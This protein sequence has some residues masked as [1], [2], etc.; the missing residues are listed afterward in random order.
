[1]ATYHPVDQVTEQ[2]ARS[3]RQRP[4]REPQAALAPRARRPPSSRRSPGPRKAPVSMAR[5]GSGAWAIGWATHCSLSLAIHVDDQPRHV[6]D[7]IDA[8][9]LEQRVGRL[10]ISVR[11]GG[12]PHDASGAGLMVER[13]N[14]ERED[15]NGAALE[16]LGGSAH[17]GDQRLRGDVRELRCALWPYRVG[18]EVDVKRQPVR[19]QQARKGV[20]VDA[21]ALAHQTE[22][23]D[24]DHLEGGGREPEKRRV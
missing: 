17:L 18:V 11:H 23:D 6:E 24:V 9:A 14:L 16:A 3:I 20:Y 7:A 12:A 1:M 19:A 10:K 8:V 13:A 15:D 22:G 2:A 21:A 5:V 4:H